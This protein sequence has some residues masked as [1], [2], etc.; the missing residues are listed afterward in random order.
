MVRAKDA[1]QYDTLRQKRLGVSN[2]TYNECV[3][4]NNTVNQD[5]LVLLHLEFAVLNDLYDSSNPPVEQTDK[6]DLPDRK[7]EQVVDE[8]IERLVVSAAQA[9]AKPVAVMVELEDARVTLWTVESPSWPEDS[10]SLTELQSVDMSL[11]YLADLEI[12]DCVDWRV[13]VRLLIV[14]WLG[15]VFLVNPRWPDACRQDSW[16]GQRRHHHVIVYSQSEVE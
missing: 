4:E 14:N 9:C 12:G 11:S 7:E 1:N 3:D 15:H 16:I 2:G 10:A 6:D 8:R 5:E 13:G